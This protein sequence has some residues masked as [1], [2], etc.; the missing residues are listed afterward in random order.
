M[1][2]RDVLTI[3]AIL[4]ALAIAAIWAVTRIDDQPATA[5]EQQPWSFD[6][7]VLATG[8]PLASWQVTP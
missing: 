5:P 4:A 8:T 6:C 7:G 2:L 1:N 3:A